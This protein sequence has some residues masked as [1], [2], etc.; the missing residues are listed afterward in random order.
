MSTIDPATITAALA[1]DLDRAF[2]DLVRLL[3]DGIY[4]GALRMLGDRHEAEDVAQEAFLRAYRALQ[5]YDPQRIRDLRLA[6]WVWTIAANLCRNR[7]RS[8]SRRPEEPGLERLDPPEGGSGPEDLAVAASDRS[9]LAAL[10]TE[11]PW[12][13]RTAVVL[14][15]VVGLGHEEIAAA[16][17]RPIGTVKSDIHRGLARLRVRH[18]EVT[19]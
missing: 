10:L 1:D 19:P 14:H 9:R 6:P 5:G 8:R 18:Q 12:P 11:L 7:Y 3:Q 16:V 13:Q 2:P 17:G 15:H 4:S